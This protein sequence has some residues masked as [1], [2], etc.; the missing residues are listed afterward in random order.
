MSV[1][2]LT[3]NF[4]YTDSYPILI[5]EVKLSFV[6]ISLQQCLHSFLLSAISLIILHGRMMEGVIIPVDREFSDSGNE[7]ILRIPSL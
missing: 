2:C 6:I 1:T 5:L 3:P 7:S 4:F